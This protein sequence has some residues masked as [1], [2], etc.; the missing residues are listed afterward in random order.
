MGPEDWEGGQ[1]DAGGNSSPNS[2]RD[3]Q[4]PRMAFAA[5]AA[6][7][8]RNKFTS[9]LSGGLRRNVLVQENRIKRPGDTILATEYL[10]NWRALGEQSSGQVL[11]KSHRPI[12]VF[13]HLG[14]SHNEYQAATTS[15][16]FIYGTKGNARTADDYGLLTLSEVNSKSY[17]LDYNSGIAQINAVGR[18]HPGG[19]SVYGGTA[20]FLF[21]DTHVERMTPLKSMQER[22]WGDR[23][24]SIN[25]ANEV[26]NMGAPQD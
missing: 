10:K 11:S 17:V 13:Y 9:E 18:S 8:P 16:G 7:I 14:S 6:I 3:K 19:D 1:I 25:G 4:A 21:V 24:Y 22:R 12:N 26:I 20:N 23:Y 2:L 15:P 5:N